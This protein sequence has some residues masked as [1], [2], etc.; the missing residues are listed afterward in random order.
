MT[1]KGEIILEIE[2]KFL[3]KELPENIETYPKSHIA[4]AYISTSPVIRVRKKDDAFI[5]TVKGPGLMEREEVEF[6]L[7][8]ESFFRLLT[9]SD[10]CIIEKTRYKIPWLSY[11]IELDIFEGT[12]EGFIMAEI[13]F[14]D[15]E[16]ATLSQLPSWFGP[17]VTMDSRFH[18]SSLSSLTKEQAPA[19]IQY[20]KALLTR[21]INNCQIDTKS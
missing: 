14:P 4:Q 3:V 16:S 10:G 15:T 13:E 21:E 11:T 6:A 2:R 12:F 7:G 18:N 8:K 1:V 5:L 20:Q 19:F 9:K 17:E